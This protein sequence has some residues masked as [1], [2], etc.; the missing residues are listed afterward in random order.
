MKRSPLH[1]RT[2]MKRRG[3]NPKAVWPPKP[4]KP[5]KKQ[6]QARKHANKKYLEQRE[7]FLRAKPVCG[8]CLTRDRNPAPAAQI[9]HSRGRIGRLLRDEKYWIGVCNDCHLWIHSNPNAARELGLLASIADWNTV[10]R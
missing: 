6:S 5:L 7:D 8:G 3:F 4:R 1:R 9:H 10:P 2:P